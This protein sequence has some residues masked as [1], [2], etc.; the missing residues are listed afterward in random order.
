MGLHLPGPV[1]EH[2]RRPG[3]FVRHI[4]HS[5]FL[6]LSSPAMCALGEQL[7]HQ[8]ILQ[9]TAALQNPIFFFSTWHVLELVNEQ[10]TPHFKSHPGE[11]VPFGFRIYQSTWQPGSPRRQG[12]L[13]VLMY[14][15]VA[16]WMTLHTKHAF[17]LR[18]VHACTPA[19][20]S[21]G[22]GANARCEALR[23]NSK[24]LTV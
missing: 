20:G 14:W 11:C 7:P 22:A 9:C 15:S 18:R 4:A 12:G 24:R 1:V 21:V 5:T 17:M 16:M 10:P 8:K 19:S 2:A 23:R 13:D 6:A 3:R